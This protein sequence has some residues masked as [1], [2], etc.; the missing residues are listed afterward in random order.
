MG[1]LVILDTNALKCIRRK[2]DLEA[3]ERSLRSVSLELAPTAL[4]AIEVIKNE[5]AATRQELLSLLARIAGGRPLL[6]LVTDKL[7]QVAEALTSGKGKVQLDVS[8][9][10]WVIYEPERLTDDHVRWAGEYAAK[11]QAPWDTSHEKARRHLQARIRAAGGVDP[12]GSIPEFLDRQWMRV[13]QLDVFIDAMWVQLGLAGTPPY[14]V[15]LK[16]ESWRLYF[17]GLGATIY[18]RGVMKET[19]R[20]VHV[21][22]VM[23][24]AYLGGHD[25]R[26]MV[27]DD[28]GLRRAANAV[29]AGRYPGSRVLTPLQLCELAA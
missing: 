23:M 26:I 11:L 5:N 28:G 17:E 18:E 14:G 8:M 21:P 4:N 1:G 6:P 22:D 9:L 24:L 20:R 10:E 7:R 19:P 12:W 2:D 16:D 25:P 3:V 27:T 13:D 29:L 15:L